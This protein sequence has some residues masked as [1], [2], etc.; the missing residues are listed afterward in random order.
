MEN[1]CAE[2]LGENWVLW[3]ESGAF[4]KNECVKGTLGEYWAPNVKTGLLRKMSVPKRLN[5]YLKSFR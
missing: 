1:Q 5:F 2:E 4:G 3:G